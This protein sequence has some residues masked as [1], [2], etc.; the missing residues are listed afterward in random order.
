[1]KPLVFSEAKKAKHDTG[2]HRDGEGVCYYPNSLPRP[3][4]KGRRRHY[5]TLK[6]ELEFEDYQDG[7]TVWLA[8]CYPYTYTGLQAYIAQLEADPVRSQSVKCKALC[9]TLAGNEVIC[10]SVTNI[11]FDP[12]A[13]D[14]RRVVLITARV[15][16]GETCS[17][18]MMKG[19]MDFLTSM[20][21]EAIELR[22]KFIFK[23]VPMVNPDGVINGNYRASLS[24]DDLNRRW[25][26]PRR[27][28]H[29][30][31]YFL[32]E[33][34]RQASTKYGVELFVDL[35]GHSKK[36]DVFAYG[37]SHTGTAGIYESVYPLILSKIDDNF[38]VERCS[39]RV[40]KSKKS[41]GRVVSWNE[42]VLLYV[43]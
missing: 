5:C 28:M 11:T 13:L 25:S 33:L 18:Y 14:R 7:D 9:R 34:L 36:K 39:F 29:P 12:T 3:A 6:F 1:M 24:G 19:V 38:K 31:V 10:L 40:A 41:T 22:D 23:L 37:C 20:R 17:S 35:H 30:E 2:W 8:Y 21:P 32:K 26:A 43:I 16:P 42:M 4:R 15:H 27:S